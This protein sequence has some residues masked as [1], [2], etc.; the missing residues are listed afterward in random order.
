MI[1]KGA[2]VWRLRDWEGG[3]PDDQVVQAQQLGLDSVCL[4]IIDGTRTRWESD[5]YFPSNQNEDL[6]PGTIAALKAAQIGVTAWGWTYGQDWLKRPSPAVGR[7]EAAATVAAMAALGISEFGVDAES[8]YNRD[9]MGPVAD[10]Y[11]R[12][13]NADGPTNRYGLCSYRFVLTHQPAFPVE[14]FATWMDFWSPQ[15]YFLGDNR[16][17]GGARQLRRSYDQY[18][19]VE[20]YPYVGV[21][22][23]YPWY[24]WR[25]T[26]KQLLAFFEAAKADGHEGIS[27]WDLPQASAVQLEAMR[28]FVWTDEPQPP[29]SDAPGRLRDEADLLRGSAQRLDDIA[30]ELED[31]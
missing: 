31:V 16:E 2:M 22:P 4:K 8:Q 26:K 21:A 14:E 7:A 30:A 15:V 20:P 24:D 27:I 13:L 28:E 12:Q 1:G 23:T 10:A 3:D 29:A 6:L 5:R 11:G 25:A 9:G 19:T 17:D 18:M